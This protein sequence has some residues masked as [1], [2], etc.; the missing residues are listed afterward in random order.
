[1]FDPFNYK[2][3]RPFWFFFLQNWWIFGTGRLFHAPTGDLAKIPVTSLYGLDFKELRIYFENYFL[4]FDTVTS[5]YSGEGGELLAALGGSMQLLGAHIACVR[6]IIEQTVVTSL[7]MGF[8][9]K[10]IAGQLWM[11]N[12]HNISKYLLPVASAFKQ[13]ILQVILYKYSLIYSI[14]YSL[15]FR[16]IIHSYITGLHIL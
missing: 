12:L 10:K 7:K 9:R 15:I 13:I 16:N 5:Q 2:H 4:H 11:E 6:F 14:F 8:F 3:F 1:M